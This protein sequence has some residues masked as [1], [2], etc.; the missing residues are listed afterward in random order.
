MHVCG[1]RRPAFAGHVAQEGLRVSI[2][3]PPAAA[4][5]PGTRF[6]EQKAGCMPFVTQNGHAVPVRSACGVTCAGGVREA[7]PEVVSMLSRGLARRHMP[8]FLSMQAASPAAWTPQCR[9]A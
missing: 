5:R 6:R 3:A 8:T 9:G 2:G 4:T 1:C 7:G